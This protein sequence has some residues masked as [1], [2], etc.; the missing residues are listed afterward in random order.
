MNKKLKHLTKALTGR[1]VK[2]SLSRTMF[3]GL[4]FTAISG[5]V[6]CS[7]PMI[8]M[9]NAIANAVGDKRVQGKGAK[10]I[11]GQIYSCNVRSITRLGPSGTMEE[12]PSTNVSL[13]PNSKSF[14]FDETTGIL[15]EDGF[16]PL[17][18]IVMQIGTNENSSIGYS[19][20]KGS[21]S[22]G[23]AVLRIQKWEVGLPF[24]FLD[25]SVLW[26][27]SCMTK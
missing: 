22:S 6:G 16:S 13:A 2:V 17:K 15:S 19:T 8:A 1:G 11:K 9:N 18:M 10:T 12:N 14:I 25:S 24:L 27:G 3:L 4:M 7:N 23:I 26:T 5:L 20:Y 21:A